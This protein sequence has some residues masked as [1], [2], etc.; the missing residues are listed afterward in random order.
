MVFPT[1]K[2]TAWRKS[3]QV[4]ATT[5]DPFFE[6]CRRKVF[7]P[8]TGSFYISQACSYLSRMSPLE[9]C[10]KDFAIYDVYST[11][12][13]DTSTVKLSIQSRLSAKLKELAF[14]D[15]LPKSIKRIGRW[16]KNFWS[17]R[18]CVYQEILIWLV[19]IRRRWMHKKWNKLKLHIVVSCNHTTHSSFKGEKPV[20]HD[21]KETNFF[22]ICAFFIP[23]Y[24][25]CIE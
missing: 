23:P 5:S 20:L 4:L 15:I 21:A 1:Q 25:C 14:I 6:K 3:Y 24:T 7:R 16:S 2:C 19:L 22:S 18:A 9:A 12:R 17:A 8:W 13:P 11:R 10:S